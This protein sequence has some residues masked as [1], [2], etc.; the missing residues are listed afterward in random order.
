MEIRL[1]D[2]TVP[3][4]AWGTAVVGADRTVEFAVTALADVSERRRAADQVQFL[5]AITANMSE[6]VVLIRQ[7][8][9]TIAYANSSY[10]AMFGYGPGELMGR[11]IGDLTAPE[12]ATLRDTIRDA[13]AGE[14]HLAR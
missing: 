14:M 9:S 11:S 3:I 10:E 13:P 4:E 12:H 8:D 5:S 6:G 7:E 1:P 2:V